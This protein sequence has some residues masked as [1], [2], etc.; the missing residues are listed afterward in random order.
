[1]TTPASQA[2]AQEFEHSVIE[3]ARNLFPADAFGGSTIYE[4]KERDGI[5]KTDAVIAVIE[6]TT[7]RKKDK[8]EKDGAKLKSAAE[9]LSRENPFTAIKAYFITRDEP[10]ADQRDAIKKIGPPVAILSFRSFQRLLIDVGT[11]NNVRKSHRFGSARDPETDSVESL[12]KYIPLEFSSVACENDILS[13]H[14]LMSEMAAGRVVVL[15]G[16]YGSGKS[17]TLRQIFLQYNRIE[18]DRNSG[19]RVQHEKFC[20]HLNLSDHQ[21]QSDPAEALIRHANKIGFP[22]PSNLIRAWRAGYAHVILDGFDEI[23]STGV[24]SGTRIVQIRRDAAQLVRK[25]IDDMPD[26]AGVLIAGREH[27]FDSVEELKSALK[28]NQSTLIVKAVDFTE[29]KVS[30]Y[31][32]Q[33]S[34]TFNLPDWLPRRPLLI[35]YLAARQV[36]SEGVDGETDPGSGWNTL[37]EKICARESRIE[38]GVSAED[39]R[40]LLHRFAT[41]ARHTSSGLGPL[42]FEDLVATYQDIFGYTPDEGGAYTVLQRLPGLQAIEGDNR[43]SFVDADMV[44]AARAGEVFDVVLNPYRPSPKQIFRGVTTALGDVG[45]EVLANTLE[46]ANINYASVDAALDQIGPDPGFDYLRCDILRAGFGFDH[47]P[48]KTTMIASVAIPSLALPGTDCSSVSFYDCLI[49]RLDLTDM[50]SVKELPYFNKC[51]FSIIDGIAEIDNL[52]VEHFSDCDFGMFSDSTST[53]N[54]I[55]ALDITDKRRV[56]LTIL[57]KVFVQSGHSRKE[58]ALYR[59]SLS[60]KQRGLVPEVLKELSS[61]G[62][63][64]AS[65]RRGTTLWTPNMIYSARVRNILG[66]P[67]TTGD[68]LISSF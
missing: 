51:S 66:A 16:D 20:L 30:E 56:A 9:R 23:F 60:I 3:I 53:M 28:V 46:T 2:E 6:C 8:A 42:R 58:N 47:S 18:I 24:R 59:G 19:T 57:R 61:A 22:H 39:V 27:Y 34:W 25:F 62:L 4:G 63:I 65:K 1:M 31:L 45:L 37:L 13:Y 7:S 38:A 26:G 15:L 17:M 41:L 32:K 12:D 33:R 49:E 35:G 54:Q 11:Y 5:F 40:A 52:A 48:A 68:P 67:I 36:L 44:D 21:G 55:L 14:N 29:N 64:H 50:L 43:R 10:T